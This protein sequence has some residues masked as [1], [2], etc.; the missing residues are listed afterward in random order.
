MTFDRAITQI[1]DAHVKL[2]DMCFDSTCTAQILLF[3]SENSLHPMSD[4]PSTNKFFAEEFF[5]VAETLS[6]WWWNAYQP[7]SFKS[8]EAVDWRNASDKLSFPISKVETDRKR[9]LPS[10]PTLE[11]VKNYKN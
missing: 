6:K 11:K 7:G 8:S 5:K 2:L 4:R 10:A 9:Q 1:K 3:V